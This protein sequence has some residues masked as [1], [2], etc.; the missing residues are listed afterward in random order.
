MGDIPSDNTF[1]A[2]GALRPQNGRE[3]KP[4]ASATGLQNQPV[5]QGPIDSSPF[6]SQYS[7]L[8]STQ[9]R[10]DVP[11]APNQ[12]GHLQFGIPPAHDQTQSSLNMGQMTAALPD[13]HSMSQN[14]PSNPPVQRPLSGAS[15]PA[16]VYQLQQNLQYAGHS[17]PN[18]HTQQ[19]YGG[20]VFPQNQF[21]NPYG[22]GQS[23]QSHPYGM[24]PPG[25]QR[26][27]G[28]SPS[29]PTF[30]QANPQYVYYP[31]PYGAQS[32]IN[33]QYGNQM[34]PM[35]GFQSRRSSLPSTQH[36]GNF[37]EQVLLSGS[38]PSAGSILSGSTL[39]GN[40]PTSTGM[41]PAGSAQGK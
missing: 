9:P 18:F 38:L 24:Y 26:S 15:T 14:Q 17:A 6:Y 11:R 12:Q 5:S 37:G 4:G 22:T 41:L 1:S 31:T 2:P 20:T 10:V 7:A 16:L 19:P 25:Q 8:S 33:P 39:H 21:S 30:P 23:V 32:H 3:N 35:M 36:P 13:Y 28:T 29:Y 27:A 40:F 34:M